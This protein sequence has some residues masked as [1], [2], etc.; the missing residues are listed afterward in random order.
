MDDSAVTIAMADPLDFETV[1]A[2]RGFCGAVSTMA[3][4]ERRRTIRASTSSSSSIGPNDEG[5]GEAAAVTCGAARGT[6][7]T[8]SNTLREELAAGTDVADYSGRTANL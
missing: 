2:V 6:T 3:S 5:R 7:G 4:G 8:A 1:S